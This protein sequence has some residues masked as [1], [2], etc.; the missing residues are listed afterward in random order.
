MA[1]KNFG[2]DSRDKNNEEEDDQRLGWMRSWK[3]EK[4]LQIV[5]TITVFGQRAITRKAGATNDRTDR[6][7]R[8]LNQALLIYALP[9]THQ[10]STFVANFRQFIRSKIRLSLLCASGGV[11]QSTL[12]AWCD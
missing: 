11:M 12:V 4:K 8:C 7:E 2:E 3:K 1:K 9:Q 5:Q 10:R 6:N